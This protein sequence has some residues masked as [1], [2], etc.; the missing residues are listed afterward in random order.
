MD[1]VNGRSS[2]FSP[3][4]R[5]LSKYLSRVRILISLDLRI[6]ARWDWRL[7]CPPSLLAAHPELVTSSLYP[8]TMVEF[9]CLVER[10]DDGW[11]CVIDIFYFSPSSSPWRGDC[12]V[13]K[14][15]RRGEKTVNPIHTGLLCFA[16][17]CEELAKRTDLL[18][19]R[20]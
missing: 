5:R 19:R 10:L 2:C 1:K 8:A 7:D 3:A 11:I 17:I 20:Q 13:R 15:N 18:S 4:I 6:D 9:P 14:I 12:F 16:A